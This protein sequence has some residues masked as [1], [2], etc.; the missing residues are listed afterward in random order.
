MSG[1]MNL[2]IPLD[3]VIETFNSAANVYGGEK[4][5]IEKGSS[6]VALYLNTK[7]MIFKD[8]E[9]SLDDKPVTKDGTIFLPANIFA[10][11]FA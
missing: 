4:I 1:N 3:I 5:V 10:K 2:M 6:I 7:K 8:N 9:Y 11:C